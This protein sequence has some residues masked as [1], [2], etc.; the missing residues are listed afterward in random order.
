MKTITDVLGLLKGVKSERGGYRALC[1]A[2]DDHDPSLGVTEGRDGR[3]LLKCRAGCETADVIRAI[4]LTFRDLG[5]DN[6]VTHGREHNSA[7]IVYPYPDESGKLLFEVVRFAVPPGTK[8]K[9]AHRRPNGAGGHVWNVDGVRH[10]LYR[11]PEVIEAAALGKRIYHVEG[12]K[13]ADRLASLGLIA[14]TAP[15][16][17]EAPWLDE[18]TAAL[19]GAD[20]IVIPDADAPGRKHARKVADA[21]PG[22]RIIELPGLPEKGDV[23]DWLDMGHTVEEL[24]RLC[25]P[26][27][28]L[29]L[30]DRRVASD[31]ARE[32]EVKIDAVPTHLPAWNAACLGRGGG[33]GLARG[34]HC[35]VAAPSNKG[36]TMMALNVAHAGLADGRIVAYLLLEG[37]R[38][39]LLSRLYPLASNISARLLQ[40]GQFYDRATFEQAANAFHTMLEDCRARFYVGDK[41]DRRLGAVVDAIREAA[42][43]GATLVVVDY[44]Q[45]VRVPGAQGVYDSTMQL[46]SAI[47]E[48]ATTL[49][50][51]TLGISQYNREALNRRGGDGLSI[52]GLSGGGSLEND[53]DQ[54]LILDTSSDERDGFTLKSCARLGKN[55][56]GPAITIPVEWDFRTFRVYEVN[57]MS[58]RRA[59]MGAAT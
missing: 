45:L 19:K 37:D 7:E 29:T 41:L 12:E 24:E 4:G 25:D 53:A 34:W 54:I 30:I 48:L 16:G 8:K 22:A 20:V 56:H 28:R 50:I 5:P 59:Q 44:L 6:G 9:F 1:P 3:V 40:P 10:V 47:S 55:R 15:R 2:H 51:V 26:V 43:M 13:D 39:D 57:P 27:R 36:K 21:V 32:N 18:Y 11:L 14:T 38:R 31:L 35:I 46:S 52:H 42:D 58:V 49:G 33:V 23:S 17:A